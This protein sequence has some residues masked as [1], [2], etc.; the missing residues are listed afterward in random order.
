MTQGEIAPGLSSERESSPPPRPWATH[1]ALLVV[2]VAFA[3][4]TVEAKVAMMPRAEGGEGLAPAAIAM[5]RMVCGAVF[6][7]TLAHAGAA[8]AKEP[9]APLGAR[10]HLALVALSV[11][12]IALNQTLFLVGLRATSP[13]A[14]ALL[15]GTIPVFAAGFG[16]LFGRER[17]EGR[18]VLG[19]VLSLAGVLVLTGIGRF[20]LGALLVSFNSASYAAYLVLARPLVR[21]L[22][23]VRVVSWVFTYGALL[24][25]P[26]GM[27]ALVHELPLLTPRG[28]GFLAYIVLMPT[29]VAYGLNAWALGRSSALLVTV[30]IYLQP[31]LA[32]LLAWVQL[33]QTLTARALGAGALILAGL[34]IVTARGRTNG[35]R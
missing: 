28:V 29:I 4:Q 3:S 15:A 26:L 18:T 5:V 14:V 2:Q 22:G 30:Y 23:A 11:L 27:G 1:A 21:T 35:V 13:F 31:L 8:R 17:L 16:V 12:G 20:D 33:G 9:T 19:L 34:A 6:F 7:Q 24:F 25:A 32:A 10:T